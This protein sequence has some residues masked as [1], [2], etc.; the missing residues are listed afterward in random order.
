MV[1]INTLYETYQDRRMRETTNALFEVLIE[2][3]RK[4]EYRRE[5]I[6]RHITGQEILVDSSID[7]T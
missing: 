3:S 2:R 5:T 6:H 7:Y 4:I 1:R